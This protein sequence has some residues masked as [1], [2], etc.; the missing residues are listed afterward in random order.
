MGVGTSSELVVAWE[1][2][3][4]GVVELAWDAVSE[5]A[6]VVLLEVC[7]RRVGPVDREGTASSI[8]RFCLWTERACS[9]RRIYIS[10]CSCL[11][12]RRPTPLKKAFLPSLIILLSV[13]VNLISSASV[14]MSGIKSSGLDRCLVCLRPRP[15]GKP[16]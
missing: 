16:S 9:I 14:G 3:S 15:P 8:T 7:D 6:S 5:V 11:G 4:V 1:S 2:V 12:V 13:G 10:L